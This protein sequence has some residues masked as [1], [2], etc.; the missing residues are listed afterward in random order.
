MDADPYRRTVDRMKTYR[1]ALA[2]IIASP[3]LYFVLPGKPWVSY[4]LVA[5]IATVSIKAEKKPEM[6]YELLNDT[7]LIGMGERYRMMSSTF[8]HGSYA[9]LI[10]NLFAIFSFAP[11]LERDVVYRFGQ[12]GGSVFAIGL[13]TLTAIQGRMVY[14]RERRT[15]GSRSLGASGL[16]LA[17]LAAFTVL[18]PM[19]GMV[20]MFLIPM[21]AWILLAILYAVT[22]WAYKAPNE[23]FDTAMSFGVSSNIHHLGHLVGMT[24]GIIAGVA[25]RL[26]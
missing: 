11:A 12:A 10:M 24:V 20:L 18:H 1:L 16:A 14:D 23:K 7:E 8:V 4:V 25:L 26:F 6:K 13:V 21:K 3:I 17:I 2:A 22:V 19:A 15:G 5:A 9:H